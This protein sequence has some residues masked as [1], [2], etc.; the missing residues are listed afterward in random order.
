M[1]KKRNEEVL[2]KVREKKKILET[3]RKRK[4]KCLRHWL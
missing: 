1:K 4:M 3:V 2:E